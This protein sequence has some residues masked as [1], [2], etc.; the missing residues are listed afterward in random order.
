[1]QRPLAA[2]VGL[3]LL[4]GACTTP[5]PDAVPTPTSSPT[6]STSSTSTELDPTPST[7]EPGRVA[8]VIAPDPPLAAA[9][10]EIGVRGAASR[11][12]GDA[13]LRVATADSAPF[14][15]DLTRF[16]TSEGYDLVCVVGSGAAA[17]VRNVAP[18]SPSTRFC[19]APASGEGMSDNVLP[20]DLRV[21]ELGY[22]A[23]TALAADGI[24]SPAGLLVSPAW[25]PQRLEVGLTAG[26]AA[27]GVESPTVRVVG[28]IEDEEVMAA[29]TSSLLEAGVEGMFALTGSLDATVV[30]VIDEVPVTEPEPSP[31][32]TATA[33]SPAGTETPT[34]GATATETATVE[35]TESEPRHAGLVA[36]PEARPTEDGAPTSDRLLA[37][38]ELHLEEAVS[39]AVTRHLEGWDTTPASVGLAE[40]AFRVAI[41]DGERGQA[42]SDAVAGAQEGIRSGDVEVPTQ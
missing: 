4:L 23:G 21:E 8:V 30:S 13:E 37:I 18:S 19:A 17:A 1:M 31:S 16:F 9:A 14:V 40:G 41:G 34:T 15:E 26:L 25:T 6:P 36:G 12:L 22:L 35:P 3:A 33:T 29:Q 2:L 27:G 11:L 5:R 32:P 24:A 38:L 28:P 39:L 10:A 42:V 7:A 20:I